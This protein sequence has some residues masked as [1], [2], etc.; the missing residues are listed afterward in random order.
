MLLG[1]AVTTCEEDLTLITTPTLSQSWTYVACKVNHEF[2]D[3][4]TTFLRLNRTDRIV[5][6]PPNGVRCSFIHVNLTDSHL[7]G[8]HWIY[9][10]LVLQ[11]TVLQVRVPP[12]K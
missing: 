3:V 9:T 2:S 5:A 10:F 1:W 7:M 8:D 11:T 12:P 4:M 6:V